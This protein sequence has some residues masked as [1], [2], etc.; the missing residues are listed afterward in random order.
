MR[1]LAVVATLACGVSAEEGEGWVTHA[2]ALSPTL[3][4]L[5]RGRM[6]AERGTSRLWIVD[7][8]TGDVRHELRVSGPVRSLAFREDGKRFVATND[9]GPLRVIDVARGTVVAN[10]AGHR[11]WVYSVSFARNRIASTARDETLRMWD[12]ASGAEL[13]RQ[14][15][16]RLGAVAL[17][18]DAS[19][20]ATSDAAG[21]VQ[22]WDAASGEAKRVLD[23]EEKRWGRALGFS[24]DGKRLAAGSR[25]IRVF[26]VASGKILAT[27]ESKMGVTAVAFS[28]DAT[29][30]ALAETGGAVR[31]WSVAD[32]QS[33][34]RWTAPGAVGALRFSADGQALGGALFTGS[35]HVWSLADESEQWTKR[36]AG[37]DCM[38]LSVAFFDDKHGVAV[39]G[40]KEKAPSAIATTKDDGRTWTPVPNACKGRLYAVDV[41]D[42]DTAIA[43]GFGGAMVRTKNRG[44]TWDEIGTPGP[45]WLASVDFAS[46]SV[47][48]VV[49]GKGQGPL[50]WKSVD[51]GSTWHDLSGTL[52]LSTRTASLRDVV[53]ANETRGFAV[54]TDGLILETDDGGASWTQRESGTKV[55]LR[56][57]RRRGA[58]IEIAGRGVV[59]RSRDD[60]RTWKP[61]GGGHAKLNDVAFADDE[62]GWATNFDGQI[63]ETTDAGRTWREVFK[64]SE[65]TIAIHI[66]SRK[67]EDRLVV[68]GDGGAILRRV[69]KR[70]RKPKRS[71][72]KQNKSANP[73]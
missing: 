34:R 8:P 6:H 49:G 55:W 28:S 64:Q 67:A 5:V 51:G 2:V 38:M 53:F 72:A 48:Y 46:S 57:I 60:G 33:P 25:R 3:T 4:T 41:L 7:A 10:L 71:K 35:C 23:V 69:D 43:V 15:N 66:R 31:L 62:R 17:S 59:L 70:E 39:G 9:H 27:I 30:L 1:W 58:T 50:L 65:L 24:R 37:I 68:T 56:S 32:A 14:S 18:P 36:S 22:L 13:W 40:T 20:L 54:G 61:L 44:R 45:H 42:R 52:P 11:G 12:A 73:G 63:M 29:H 47:G 19:T 26:D 16:L 21:R